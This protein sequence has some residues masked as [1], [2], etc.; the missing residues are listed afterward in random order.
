MLLLPM[1]TLHS[2]TPVIIVD[3]LKKATLYLETAYNSC[4]ATIIPTNLIA[5][6]IKKKVR[7]NEIE[8]SGTFQILHLIM[9][10]ILS[11]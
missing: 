8:I 5:V 9:I 6:T 2:I 10:S 1:T 4:Y 7:D 11:G 3:K